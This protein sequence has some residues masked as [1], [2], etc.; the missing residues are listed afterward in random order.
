MRGT[1]SSRYS[2][3]GRSW[4]AQTRVALITLSAAIS[5]SAPP[6]GSATTPPRAPP[7]RA[8]T[9]PPSRGAAPDHAPRPPVALDQPRHLAA[10]DADGPE[11]LG[12]AEDRQHEPHIV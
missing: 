7:S 1:S 2:S 12:L 5:N 9:P 4:S 8:T 3:S 10:V 6:S 11:A